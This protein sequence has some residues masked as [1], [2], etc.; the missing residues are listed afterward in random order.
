MPCPKSKRKHTPITS[1]K[2]KKLFG[3]ARGIQKGEVS[4]SYSSAA[5]KLAES[6]SAEVIKSH[7]TEA[8][9]KKLPL[10][11]KKKKLYRKGK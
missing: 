3:I 2:Q 8:K 6:Q 1:E 4:S 9:G 7:L 11:V 10:Y 5:A